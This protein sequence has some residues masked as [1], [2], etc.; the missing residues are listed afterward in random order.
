[1]SVEYLKKYLNENQLK[2]GIK[3]LKQGI[4]PQYII[5]EVEFYGHIFKVNENVLIPRFETEGLVEIAINKLKNKNPKIIDLGTGSGAIAI[6]LKKEIECTVDAIDISNKALDVAKEN[7]L[8]NKVNINFIEGDMIELLRE[9]YDCI[10]SNPPY[11]SY[12]EEIEKIVKDNE[13]NLALYAPNNGL[14]FYEQILKKAKKHLNKNGI[15][16]FEIG[17]MQGK[18]IQQL[19]KK[20]LNSN[21]EII[22]DLSDKDRYI[23]IELQ[24]E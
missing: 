8:L 22:K 2:E 21:A 24:S 19:A 12:D 3:K 20:Y 1:M 13:P 17:Y 9:K 7:A 18:E 23:Y 5:G 11:I 6:T 16:L 14:Y 10:I 4:P 15:I